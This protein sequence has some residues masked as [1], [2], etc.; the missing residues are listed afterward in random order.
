[1]GINNIVFVINKYDAVDEDEEEE[2]LAE[3]KKR[4]YRAFD[5]DDQEAKLRDISIYPL[6]AK[7]ALQGIEQGNDK[8]LAASGLTNLQAKLND[9][10]FGG[11]MEQEKL[12][13]YKQRLRYLLAA[14]EREIEREKSMKA[15][16]I[17]ELEEAARAL[18]QILSEKSAQ[19]SN[20]NGYVSSAKTKIYAMTDKS[21]QHFY[22]KLRDNIIELIEEYKNQDFKNFVEKT[23]PKLIQ[24]N[25]GSWIA[26]YGPHIDELLSLMEQEL[27]R[28]LSKQFKQKIR[29]KTNRGT[30]LK[31]LSAVV[32]IEATDI[33]NTGMKV[34][35]LTAAGTVV[36]YAALSPVLAP[37]MAIFGKNKLF[38]SLLKKNLAEAKADAIPQMEGQL[39]KTIM[40]LKV[41]VHNYID[42]QAKRI[43]KNTQYAYETVLAEVKKKI[44][45]QIAE[46]RQAGADVQRTMDMLAGQIAEIH[47]IVAKLEG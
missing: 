30:N 18:Q 45:E 38:D 47:K 25:L 2:F 37:I 42:Q 3:V 14:L 13:S 8:L 41:H 12:N 43:E 1:M 34:T 11:N 7:M 4:L 33:S 29:L 32:D 31:N 35:A 22:G 5:M 46:K 36:I 28:G 26:A 10:L 27:A 19:E 23:I 6:S 16:N 44:E 17:D 24:R 39:T 9:M 40:E 15:A 21:L 20:V